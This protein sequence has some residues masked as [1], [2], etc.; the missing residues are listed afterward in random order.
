MTA[1]RT[2]R[3]DSGFSLV[4]L[5]IVLALISILTLIGMPWMFSSINRA[6][7]VGAAKE[8]STL[9]QVAR[10][11][12][13]KQG[14]PTQVIYVA[15]ADS[16]LAFADS[17][18]DGIFTAATDR[19]IARGSK[20]PKGIYL[21]GPTDGAAVGANAIADWDV[22]AKCVDAKPGPIFRTDGSANCSGAFR[23][24]DVHGN[25]LETRVRFPATAKIVIR[26]WFGGADA[27]AQWFE[28][29]EAGKEWTW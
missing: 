7:L 23:F 17:D 12:S 9:M 1:A 26:K 22:A 21:W 8:T 25:F 3:A 15:A 13:I 11:E 20:L 29:G 10:L 19:V 27:D 16:L 24:R 14:V 6:K 28:N 2:R 4:E 18:Q 5:L